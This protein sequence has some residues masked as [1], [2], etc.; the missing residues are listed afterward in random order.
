M[1]VSRLGRKLEE[2]IGYCENATI[3]Y[4]HE[5][6]HEGIKMNPKLLFYSA[7]MMV[8][9]IQCFVL[10]APRVFFKYDVIRV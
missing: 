9:E 3:G 5:C 2:R 7:V 8:V 10:A 6:M 1:D 4:Q